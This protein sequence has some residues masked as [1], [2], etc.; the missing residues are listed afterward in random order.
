[1]SSERIPVAIESTRRRSFA[2]ALDWPGW[3][4]SGKTPDLAIDAFLAYAP[5]FAPV[6]ARAGLDL[7][8]G[9]LDVDVVEQR[10]GGAGTDYGV[11]SVTFEA[12]RTPTTVADAARLVALL[13][14]AW[15]TFDAV[16]AAAPAELRKGPRGGGRDTA[17]MVEHVAGAEQAY[18]GALG[19]RAAMPDPT[20]AAAVARLREALLGPLRAP[21]NGAPIGKWTQ[22]YGARRI[23]WHALDHAWEIEDRS[24]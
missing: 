8:S 18:A 21:S 13:E 1:M 11:P 24:T 14:A 2:V 9:S 20:D 5:R 22:R 23:A 10:D 17:K 6:A 7:P 16:A 12:D 3:S 15:A 19:I 4:R